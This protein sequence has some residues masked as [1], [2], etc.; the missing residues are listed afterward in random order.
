MAQD[1]D[2]SAMYAM[3][4][5]LRNLGTKTTENKPVCNLLTRHSSINN[6]AY[7]CGYSN[8]PYGRGCKRCSKYNGGQAN[9]SR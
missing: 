8:R 5:V 4:E 6:Y 3:P 7:L 9:L 1:A 2:A